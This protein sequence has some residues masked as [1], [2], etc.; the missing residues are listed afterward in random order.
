VPFIAESQVILWF[1]KIA[2]SKKFIAAIEAPIKF[3]MFYVIS[4]T[5]LFEV[6]IVAAQKQA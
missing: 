3:R 2:T 5:V 1:I 6:N 4:A